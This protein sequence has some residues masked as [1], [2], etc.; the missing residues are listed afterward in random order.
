[1]NT[2]WKDGNLP[3]MADRIELRGLK[4]HGRHGV[5]TAERAAGQ[6]FIVDLT[7]WLDF[8]AA[9]AGD[10]L[11]RTVDYSELAQLAHKIVA[12]SPRDLIET[13]AAEIADT[14]MGAFTQLY[15][16]E[17]TVH[18]PHAPIPLDFGDVAVVARRSR[19]GR[20]QGQP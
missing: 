3:N 15:A 13:V 5:L 18:K 14:A 11:E 7:C 8:T 19:G 2:N 4:V 12:G 16:I 6:E 1:M 9:A 10:D 17:V 20:G